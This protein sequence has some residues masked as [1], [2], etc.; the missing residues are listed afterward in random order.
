MSKMAVCSRY[1]KYIMERTDEVG[2]PHG[3]AVG[4]CVDV[5]VELK[6]ILFQHYP[7]EFDDLLLHFLVYIV[8]VAY[9]S[10]EWC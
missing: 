3:N 8:S 1:C 9:G 10:N 5:A 6:V 4:L 2:G 7:R